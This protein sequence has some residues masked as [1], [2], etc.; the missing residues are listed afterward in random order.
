MDREIEVGLIAVRAAARLCQAVQADMLSAGVSGVTSKQDGSPVTVADFGSQAVVNR[1]VGEAFPGDVI[2]AE[3]DGSV[4]RHADGAQ[5]RAVTR[6][7]CEQVGAADPQTVCDWIDLGAGE[8]SGRFWVLDPIDG[9]KGFLRR[10]QYAIALGLIE[11]GRV[12]LG[13]LACPLLPCGGR[14][15]VVFASRRGHGTQAF[16]LD[17]RPLGPARVAPTSDVKRAVLV[18]SV[19]SA[20]TNHAASATLREMVGTTAEPLRMDSQAKYAAVAHGQADVYLRLPNT[21]TP[22]YRENIWDHAAGV[23]VV[24]EAG[25]RVTDCY[26]RPL[27]WTQGRRLGKNLGVITTNGRL[28]ERLV[29]VLERVLDLRGG[30]CRGCDED[31][32]EVASTTTEVI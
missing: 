22:D 26:G 8:P 10:G 4:L 32:S 3:E 14:R 9:T 6:F 2:V 18:E 5:L 20:H 12:E 17:G 24:E 30:G 11:G 15:G 1:I 19:E 31:N 13:F 23:L 25:G 7:A 27:D 29:T 16:A 28:H 21:K